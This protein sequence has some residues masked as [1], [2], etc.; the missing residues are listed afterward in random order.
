MKTSTVRIFALTAVAVFAS[1]DPGCKKDNSTATGYEVSLATNAKFGRY[2]VDK[3]GYTLYIFSND[4]DGRT[5]CTGACEQLWPH[6]SVSDLTQDKLG[7]GLDIADF[8]TIN[9]NGLA[10]LRYKKWPLYYY[11]PASGGY[12]NNSNVQEPAGQIK[13]DGYSNVWYVAKPDYSILLANAQLIGNDGLNYTSNYTQGTGKTLYFT[14]DKGQTLYIFSK[15]SMNYNTFTKYDFSN[16]DVWPI[17]ESLR[18]RVPSTIDNS[19]F[20]TM[21]V[22]G[23]TQITYKGWPLY[24]FGSDNSRGSNKGVSFPAPGIWPVAV[25]DLAPAPEIAYP[26]EY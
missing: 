22:F 11:A 2:L 9:V 8:D 19:L 24:H 26:W 5:S 14:D 20:S 13:G 6:F 4:F 21:D 1:I 10:Q 15:D 16:N 25:K 3:N 17:Y 23:R 18:I 7:F 12:G